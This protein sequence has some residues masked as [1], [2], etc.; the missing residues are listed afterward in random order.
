MDERKSRTGLLAGGLFAVLLTA[1]ATGLVVYSHLLGPGDGHAPGDTQDQTIREQT[2][3]QLDE[4]RTQKHDQLQEYLRRLRQ[5]AAACQD[6]PVIR[7]SFR[8]RLRFEQ[9][10][11]DLRRKGETIAALD[12][13][14]QRV[15]QHYLEHYRE[16]L[17]LLMVDAEGTIF[18]EV[19]SEGFGG[20]NFFQVRSGQQLADRLAEGSRQAYVDYRVSDVT[21][22]PIACFVEPMVIDSRFRGW[23]VLLCSIQRINEIFTRDR[24]LGRT[25]EVFLVNR[26]CQML[27]DSR[28]RRDSSILEQ[29][30]SPENIL[31]KFRQKEGRK[32]V[33]D[34]RGCRALTSFEVCGLMDSQW[35]LIAKI[36]QAEV[37]TRH[38]VENR[39]QSRPAL[40]AAAAE[41]EPPAGPAHR[42]PEDAVLVQM[43]EFRRL[44]EQES[45][46][47][48]ILTYGVNTC[49]AVVICLP[50]KFAYLGHL[51]NHDSLYG[52][53]GQDL[54]GHMIQRIRTYEIC[55]FQMRQLQVVLVAPHDK[56]LGRAVDKLVAA[57]FFLSQIRF[58]RN[59]LAERATVWHE[60]GDGNCST[61]IRWR[62]HDGSEIH[63][64]A[65]QTPDL[66]QLYKPLVDY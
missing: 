17:N 22:E 6:D 38:Y 32:T 54:L 4:I 65:D 36:D 12:A 50:G 20:T 41:V 57:G 31:A 47:Q 15:G 62:T 64:V 28:F 34:Y 53:A 8:L 55:P 33:T 3:R 40:I 58:C 29:H 49:T 30:L 2:Y 52:P 25:G 9:L 24:H 35:L 23:V 19:R 48:A 56:S 27:T 14:G 63:Q 39:M 13:L 16:F 26:D 45:D 42:P 5:T 37:L 18:H 10:P 7:E 21:G 46:S 1:S 59:R 61:H 44:R 43:D 51:S 66:G 11:R 60:R